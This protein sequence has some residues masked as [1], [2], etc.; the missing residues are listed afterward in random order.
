M[1]VK[2][3]SF[4]QNKLWR[5]KTPD[6]MES[7][8]S[9][10]DV[11]ILNDIDFDKQ[12]R[13]KLQEETTEVVTATSVQALIEELADVY[14]VIDAL[15]VL[16]GINKQKLIAMQEKKRDMKGGFFERKYVTVSHHPLESFGVA[17]CL[18][19]PEE[20]PEITEK[21]L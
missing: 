19:D 17:Y 20:Y 7:T 5:D 21:V 9:K 4:L 14:E 8:G 6:L 12:L 3:R 16:H 13:S 2:Y 1:V 10:I 15:C 11:T 18:N